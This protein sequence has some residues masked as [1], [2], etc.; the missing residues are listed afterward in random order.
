MTKKEFSREA[1]AG[2]KDKFGVEP[3]DLKV[4]F[5]MK[6]SNVF[7]EDVVLIALQNLDREKTVEIMNKMEEEKGK[8]DP[9]PFLYGC[10]RKEFNRVQMSKLKRRFGVGK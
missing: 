6:M 4:G 7:G 2:I 3:K 8:R 9:L 1:F 5:L 10:C